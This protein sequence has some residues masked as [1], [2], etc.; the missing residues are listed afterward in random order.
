[1]PDEYDEKMKQL[2][3]ENDAAHYAQTYIYKEVPPEDNPSAADLEYRL[4]EGNHVYTSM[5]PLSAD[6]SLSRIVVA[7]SDGINRVFLKN[8]K[9]GDTYAVTGHPK[10]ALTEEEKTDADFFMKQRMVSDMEQAYAEGGEE[11]EEAGMSLAEIAKKAQYE[12]EGPKKL[13]PGT[14]RVKA[15]ERETYF[16]PWETAP[17]VGYEPG[18]LQTE[19]EHRAD[20]E[21]MGALPEQRQRLDPIDVATTRE[22]YES[23]P[24]PT[25]LT[26]E[27]RRQRLR[28]ALVGVGME[29]TEFQSDPDDWNPA[30]TRYRDTGDTGDVGGIV[31]ADDGTLRSTFRTWE[32]IERMKYKPVEPKER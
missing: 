26:E 1:M 2:R 15:G 20:L 8:T 16:A 24:T 19:E 6:L 28:A 12:Q 11:G 31:E 25:P 10:Y 7:G 21:R 32:P 3:Q 14:A 29:D 22:R 13:S 23:E 27:E 5:N 18:E 17:Q 9:T 4:Q 30:E